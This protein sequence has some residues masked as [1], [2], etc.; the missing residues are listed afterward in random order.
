MISF[1]EEVEI[2]LAHEGAVAIRVARQSLRAIAL[3]DAQP[4]IEFA[5]LPRHNRLEKSILANPIRGNLFSTRNRNSN[6]LRLRPKRP[7]NEIIAYPMRPQNSKRI[8]MRTR[9]KNAEFI[10]GETENF[11]V[12]HTGKASLTRTRPME[13]VD[14]LRLGCAAARFLRFISARIVR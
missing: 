9:Q 4:V 1:R 13:T 6:V 2:D 11:E 14:A 12:T 7:D 5:V 8:G 3:D 10:D